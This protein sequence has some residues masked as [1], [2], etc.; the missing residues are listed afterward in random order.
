MEVSDQTNLMALLGSLEG[1]VM[2]L[3]A[4]VAAATTKMNMA[5]GGKSMVQVDTGDGTRHTVL[6][7]SLARTC[8]V[9]F[10]QAR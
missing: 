9:C 8:L 6:C 1:L 5:R 7:R 4:M 2:S 10:E 3:R